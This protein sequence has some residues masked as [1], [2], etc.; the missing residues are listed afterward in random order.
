MAWPALPCPALP[1]PGLLCRGKLAL[2]GHALHFVAVSSVLHFS[3]FLDQPFLK[4]MG[5]K[6]TEGRKGNVG[7]CFEA[8]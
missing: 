7:D 3:G 5:N 1:C 2:F 4:I 8:S 6:C